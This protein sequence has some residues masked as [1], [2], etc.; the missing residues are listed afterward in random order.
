MLNKPI[1]IPEIQ[2]P[3]IDLSGISG[4]LDGVTSDLI[5]VANNLTS[6]AGKL[7]GLSNGSTSVNVDLSSVL[8]SLNT[9]N[10]NLTGVGNTLNGVNGK[11]D[12][13]YNSLLGEV[14]QNEQHIINTY[15]KA[16]EA[17]NNTGGMNYGKACYI[18]AEGRYNQGDYK[19]FGKVF[20]YTQANI[21]GT[22]N[23][24]GECYSWNFTNSTRKPIKFTGKGRV[25]VHNCYYKGDNKLP[26][27]IWFKIDDMALPSAGF[28]ITAMSKMPHYHNGA[29]AGNGMSDTSNTADFYFNKSI[30]IYVSCFYDATDM[31]YC[32]A[33][34]LVEW[35]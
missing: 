19:N 14:N 23:T 25:T 31:T 10:S 13:Q 30:E 22:N 4:K 7:D 27:F 32:H 34:M 20:D 28:D 12:T 6:I 2:I 1:V 26:V 21:R 18:L 35:N 5:G 9:V 11:L 8:N 16:Q 3:E 17:V 33:G 29:I 15:N 24:S